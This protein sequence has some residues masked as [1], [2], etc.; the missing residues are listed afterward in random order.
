MQTAVFLSVTIGLAYGVLFAA[1][2][3]GWLLG[4][5]I[6]AG[7]GLLFGVVLVIHERRQRRLDAESDDARGTIAARH[8]M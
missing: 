8:R 4:A 6:G 7:I 5:L 3:A 2:D 1:G